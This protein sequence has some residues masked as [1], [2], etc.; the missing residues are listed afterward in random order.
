MFLRKVHKQIKLVKTCYF[1]AIVKVRR[2]RY[3]R[4]GTRHGHDVRPGWLQHR[5]LHRCGRQRQQ[6]ADNGNS[7]CPRRLERSS[8]NTSTK[9]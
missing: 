8:V 2:R 7:F 3:F 4:F 5:Q 1:E 6:R 9:R